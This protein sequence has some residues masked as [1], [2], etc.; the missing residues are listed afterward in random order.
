VAQA[1]AIHAYALLHLGRLREAAAELDAAV[2]VLAAARGTED[3]ATRRAQAWLVSARPAA[4]TA[5]AAH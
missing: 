1:H 4:K 3:P 5:S 2:P